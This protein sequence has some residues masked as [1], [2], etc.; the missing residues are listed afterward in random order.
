MGEIGGFKKFARAET[1]DR[2]PAERVGDPFELVRTLPLVERRQ[3]GPPCLVC[4]A[5]F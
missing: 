5:H 3:Q 4:G 2:A 1:P